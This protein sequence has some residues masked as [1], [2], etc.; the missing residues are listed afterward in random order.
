MNN[1]PKMTPGEKSNN[2]F[3]SEVLNITEENVSL[4]LKSLNPN[5][6]PG[7]DKLYPKLLKEL[8]QELSIP[9]TYLF[10]LSI[11][12]GLLP[13]DWKDAEVTP[14]YKKGLKTDPG[15]YR[16][17]SL[18]SIVCKILESF[19]RDTIQIH[20]EQ[21]KLYSTCQHGFRRKKSC[22]SQLLEVMEDFTHF[23][24]KKQSFDVIYLDFKKA[25]D[26]V[27][28]E[29]L[30][31]KLEGYGISGNLLKWIRSFL[32][33]RTQRVKIGNEFSER[34][35]VT[36]GIPQGSILGPILFTIFINDLPEAIKSI[37]KIFADDTKIYNTSDNHTILQ[38]DFDYME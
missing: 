29:R 26:S 7:P 8:H 13:Q 6:S 10:K 4:K 37:C 1:I 9:F 23:M 20:M 18:T 28:H 5:K 11:K 3:I 14:I 24:D 12:E 17:V 32:E 2:I 21:H 36:S 15:N 27:P 16:P 19:I 38:Q 30:L 34:S 33:N 31:V 22:T 35:K 25:F